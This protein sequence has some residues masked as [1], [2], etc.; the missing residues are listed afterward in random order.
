MIMNDKFRIIIIR[1]FMA[2]FLATHDIRIMSTL[3]CHD[4]KRSDNGD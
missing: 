3:S 4:E 2:L 1:T